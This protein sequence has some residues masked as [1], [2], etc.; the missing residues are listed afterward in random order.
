MSKAFCIIHSNAVRLHDAQMQGFGVPLDFNDLSH[1]VLSEKEE[2][3][4]VKKVALYLSKYGTN[5]PLFSLKE[6]Q[7][8]FDMGRLVADSSP[9]MLNVWIEEHQDAQLRIEGHWQEVLRKQEEARKLRI[10]IAQLHEEKAEASRK[11]APLMIDLAEHERKQI[12]HISS[13]WVVY[14]YHKHQKCKKYVQTLNQTIRRLDLRLSSLQEKLER[15]LKAPPPVIQPLPEEKNNAM[16]IIFFLYMPLDFQ[17]LSRFSFTAQQL[18]IPQP[19][20]SVWGGQEGSDKYN[21]TNLVTRQNNLFCNVSWKNHYNNHQKSQYCQPSHS[22]IGSDY[23]VLLYAQG[24]CVPQ[25]IGSSSVDYMHNMMDGI[26]YPDQL[27]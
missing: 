19:W 20:T 22:R 7:S 5:K 3:E 21:I 25:Q 6:E 12:N 10:E 8:T 11:L 14:D 24:N 17:L 13:S 4:V 18:L 1:L 16:P 26:W 2:W 15:A 27:R 23:H 9:T